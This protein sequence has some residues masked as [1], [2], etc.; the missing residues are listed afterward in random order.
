M[1]HVGYVNGR[2]RPLPR[3]AVALEDRGYQFADGIYEVIKLVGGVLCDLERHLDRMERS[4]RELR[5]EPPMSRAALASVMAE[6]VRRNRRRDG[7]LYLQISRGVAAR[8]HLFPTD[9]SPQLVMTL[10][11]P[12]RPSAQQLEHGV[13]VVTMADERWARCDIK[14]ISLLAN[15]LAKQRAQEAGAY[16]AWLVDRAGLITEASA[17]NAYI[18]DDRD[19][20]I[21][22]PLGPAILGG[23][24]R[25]VL[26][27]LARQDGI[28]VDER[29][30]SVDEAKA[31][32]EAILTSTTNWVMPVTRIDDVALGDDGLAGPVSRRLSSLYA[33][34]IDGLIGPRN[35]IRA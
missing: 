29:P 22:R 3:H 30:F 14:S 8:N 32:R 2:Y 28:E 25:Q 21:T 4:L 15:V 20:L 19:R 11:G 33:A 9:A 16:E 26:L 17:A 6:L 27:E 12:K 10:R 7:L 1:P 31:S 24:T 35:R 5:I 18:V 34:H 23:I 13:R